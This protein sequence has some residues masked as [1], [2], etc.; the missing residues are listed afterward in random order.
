MTAVDRDR[1]GNP[2]APGLPYARGRIL[3]STEDDIAKLGRA[4]RIVERR[5][6]KDGPESVFNFS[7]LERSLPLEAQELP[8]ADDEIAP[9]LYGE[10]LRD[11]ALE[12]LGGSSRV[13]D[14]MLFN[15]LT[16]ATI[17][18]HLA[19][20]KGGDV[21]VGIAPSYSHPTLVRAATHVGARFLDTSSVH[22]FA[23]TLERE[24]PVTLVA[25]TRLAVTY[26]LLPLDVI[27]EVV[28]LARARG[29]LVY[30]DDAGGARVGPAVFGQPR[31]LELGVDV[32]A[33]GLDKYGTSGPRLGL[34][35]GERG[36]VEKIRA[37]AFEFGLEARPMLYPAAVRSLE[38]YTPERVRALVN[39][40]KQVAAA[41]RGML[42]RRLRETPVTAQFLAE[43]ILETA[44]ERAGLSRAPIVP[45][46][47]TAALAMLLLEEH[48]ILTVHFAGLPP[49]TSSLLFKFIPPETLARFGGPDA[50]AEAVDASLSRLAGLIGE[51]EKIRRLLLG[52]AGG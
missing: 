40:T 43:E 1:F 13:H 30:V 51:P 45:Y 22:A 5:I 34:L 20:V 9:A 15:R 49:G 2:F 31:M 25:L 41:L 7:G 26:D 36:L 19:L 39:A 48:G 42:G 28:R 29:A 44:L 35:A 16:A 37:R 6:Q 33:T 32:G 4:W 18:T 24:G 38:G 50:L 46:E 27:R 10:R 11:L 52:E 47:A 14:V 8:F 17:A 23:R 12:H 21:V 3:T